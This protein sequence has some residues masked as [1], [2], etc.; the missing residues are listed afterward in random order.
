MKFHPDRY[1]AAEVAVQVR[2]TRLCFHGVPDLSSTSALVL[3]GPRLHKKLI[4]PPSSDENN[5]IESS[6]PA[7]WSEASSSSPSGVN[8]D[9]L[10]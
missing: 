9:L 8:I 4:L 3:A 1:H 2:L 10:I 7:A 5:K 6:W